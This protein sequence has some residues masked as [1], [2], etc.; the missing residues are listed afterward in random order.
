MPR[1]LKASLASPLIGELSLLLDAGRSNFA[2]HVFDRTEPRPC[3]GK[4][5]GGGRFGAFRRPDEAAPEL[6]NPIFAEITELNSADDSSA[7]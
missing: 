6:F 2:L 3:N 4:I 7:D 1:T 5:K